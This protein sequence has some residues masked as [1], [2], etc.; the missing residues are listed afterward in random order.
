V[1]AVVLAGGQGRRMGAPERGG[2][3]GGGTD[4]AMVL[5][6]GRPLI[7][8]VLARLA[9]QVAAI[10]ISANGDPARFAAFALPVLADAPCGPG[11]PLAGLLAGARWAMAAH[12]GALLLSAPCDVPFL[13]A[14]LVA[15]LGAGRLPTC[16]ASAG[17]L[18]PLVAL[19]RPA[20]LI[21]AAAS[22]GSARA[23]LE[24]LGGASVAWAQDGAFMNVND[25]ATLRAACRSISGG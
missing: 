22:G 5:L 13:P 3:E 23:L 6:A 17:R 12:P 24:S 4:K 7:A 1:V 8:H 14:D 20:A 25:P 2:A 10:A 16:A 11:G 9:P 19:W 18:H 21:A 15:R